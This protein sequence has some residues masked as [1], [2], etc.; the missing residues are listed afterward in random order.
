[1]IGNE[2]QQL[3]EDGKTKPGCLKTEERLHSLGYRRGDRQVKEERQ[4]KGTRGGQ[5]HRQ[6]GTF[7]KKTLKGETEACS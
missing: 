1:M 3:G 2:K 5:A 6:C 7:D 4:R